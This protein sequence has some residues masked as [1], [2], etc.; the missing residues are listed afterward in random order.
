MRKEN[1]ALFFKT[2]AFEFEAGFWAHPQR[3]NLTSPLENVII[4]LILL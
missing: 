1:S 2:L 3:S 4:S